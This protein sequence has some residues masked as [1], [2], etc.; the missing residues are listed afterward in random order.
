MPA[1]LCHA[2]EPGRAGTQSEQVWTAPLVRSAQRP[3]AGCSG[4]KVLS[5][6]SVTARSGWRWRRPA[7]AHDEPRGR[8]AGPGHQ[9][10]AEAAP[11]TGGTV[12][13]VRSARA[14]TIATSWRPSGRSCCAPAG[15][16]AAVRPGRCRPC[17]YRLVPDRRV[18]LAAEEL[19]GRVE[20]PGGLAYFVKSTAEGRVVAWYLSPMGATR[21]ELDVATWAALEAV[22][23]SCAS[24][25]RTRRRCSSTPCEEPASAGSSRRLLPAGGAPAPRVARALGR[26]SRLAGGSDLLEGLRQAR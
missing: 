23:P 13:P 24:Y 16:L 21:W 4:R 2:G 8:R 5:C 17:R 25:G 12:R 1:C 7:G 18:R 19:P 22:S 14:A 15:A 26:Q 10:V 20:V 9:A 6:S 3:G 11:G